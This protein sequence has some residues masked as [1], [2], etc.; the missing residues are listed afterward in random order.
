L[1]GFCNREVR[2]DPSKSH[3]AKTHHQRR[4]MIAGL[5]ALRR[6]KAVVPPPKSHCATQNNRIVVPAGFEFVDL[7]AMDDSIRCGGFGCEGA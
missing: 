5:E 6:P 1:F 3:R 4:G 7:G 2:G